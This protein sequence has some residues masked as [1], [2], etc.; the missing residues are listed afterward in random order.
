MSTYRLRPVIVE[1]GEEDKFARPVTDARGKSTLRPANDNR[2]PI[3]SLLK[4]I[5]GRALQILPPLIAAGLVIF[6]MTN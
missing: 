6:V 5:A 1:A 4:L 2:R 3:K